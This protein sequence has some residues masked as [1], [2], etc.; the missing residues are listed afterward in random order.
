MGAGKTASLSIAAIEG[1]FDSVL[2]ICPASLKTTWFNELSY[3]IPER[4]ISI[5]GGTSDLKK[6]ELEQYLGYSI[7]KS[8]KTVNE[9]QE[10]AKRKGKWDENRFVIVNY[11]ILDE[12]YKLPISRKK[13]DIEDAERNSPMLQFINGKKGLIIIDE[14][15]RLSNMKSQQYKIISNLIK[16][17]KPDSV[18]LATG[19]PITNNP[20][21]LFN[22]LSLIEN[23]ITSDWRKYMKRY[24]GAIEVPKNGEEKEKRNIISQEFIKSRNKRNWYE[25]TD[26][27]K[28]ELND[29][30]SKKCKMNLIY[31]EATNLEELKERI[32]HIYLRRTKDEFGELPPKYVHERTYY[33]TET[34]Q[35]EYDK[36][37]DEYVKEKENSGTNINI[38]DNKDLLEGG[39]YRRYLSTQMVPYTIS[40]AERCIE[41]GEKVVI[42]CC[43][44]EELYL[45]K[46]HFNEKCV[47]YNGKISLK[48]KDKA[49]KTFMTDDSCKVF[50]GNLYSAGVGLTLTASRVVIFNTFSFVPSDNR[51]GEDRVHRFSQNRDVHIFYQFFKN[52]Q[53][54]KMWNIVLKKELIIDKLIKTEKEKE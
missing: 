2:I 37:W 24:C 3:Y 42:F 45:L 31:K 6:N 23:D 35:E 47:I 25:L 10:E 33:L 32:K 9:L 30:I 13:N 48:E 53:Y 41:K 11:D 19:T 54:E 36:L 17:G 12:F 39:I 5:I 15:H 16:K 20:Q 22:V 51:Q 34:Q 44:D 27:E 28:K 38:E 29:E 8:N 14:A 52:T 46:D 26:N 7:G 40:L 50:I 21:N 49:V 43:Y 18:Y 4:E 1:N